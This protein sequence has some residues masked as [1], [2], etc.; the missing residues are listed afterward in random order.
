MRKISIFLEDGIEKDSDSLVLNHPDLVKRDRSALIHLLIKQEAFKQQ[1]T[2]MF[3]AALAV[4]ESKGW[5]EEE[6][7]CSIV[8]EKVS[9]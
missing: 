4:D 7:Y 6:E 8:D 9:S 2:A 5:S 3:A 1:R